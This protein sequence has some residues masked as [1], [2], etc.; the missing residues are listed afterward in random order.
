MVSL[1]RNRVIASALA[2]AMA[3]SSALAATTYNVDPVHSA[4]LYKVKH[5]DVSHS[6][7]RIDEPKG[8]IVIGDDGSPTSVSVEVE[9]AKVDTDSDKRDDHLRGPDF[10]DAKQFPTLSF[11]STSIK[12]T[13][14]NTFE[15]VGDFSLKGV[16]KSITI[17]VNKVGQAD[18]RMGRRA[19]FDTS[20]TI[21]RSEYNMG[22]MVG[23]VGDDVTIFVS[24]EGVAE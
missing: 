13:G 10:F 12:K 19:G 7:G 4:L 14:E 24:V 23:P 11:K 20:F 17:T 2:L 8:S 1:L 22:G 21:K 3:S 18:T 15:V 16:T 6:W 5:L 9:A